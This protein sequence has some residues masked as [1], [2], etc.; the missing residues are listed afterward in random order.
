M[1]QINATII[2]T[3]ASNRNDDPSTVPQDPPMDPQ[4]QRDLKFTPELK[5]IK[6]FEKVTMNLMDFVTGYEDEQERYEVDITI[7]CPDQYLALNIIEMIDSYLND[8]DDEDYDDADLDDFDEDFD[9]DSD[10]EFDEEDAVFKEEDEIFDEDGV[11]NKESDDLKETS[12][13]ESEKL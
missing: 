13:S 1:I 8:D 11:F 2:D 3:N 10:I 4:I 5:G 12:Q 6:R 9:D 7:R